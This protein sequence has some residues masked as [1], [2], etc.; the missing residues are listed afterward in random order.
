[1][2]IILLTLF[3]CMLCWVGMWA[4]LSPSHSSESDT[5]H[6]NEDWNE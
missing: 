6:R 3:Y 2:K 4:F 5:D 1:M